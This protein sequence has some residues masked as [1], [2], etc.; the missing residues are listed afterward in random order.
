MESLR[1]GTNTLHSNPAYTNMQN[2]SPCCCGNQLVWICCQQCS[3]V[4]TYSAWLTHMCVSAECC[5]LVYNQEPGSAAADNSQN[6]PARHSC[7]DACADI[8]DLF[9]VTPPMGGPSSSFLQDCVCVSSCAQLYAVTPSPNP[10]QGLL[11][12]VTAP[13]EEASAA[14]S[15]VAEGED[16]PAVKA[17]LDAG[18]PHKESDLPQ[19]AP[20]EV[21]TCPS[22]KPTH[23]YALV[24]YRSKGKGWF[25]CWSDLCPAYMSMLYNAFLK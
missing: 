12:Q 16:P 6:H 9:Q 19:K 7:M 4:P 20:K 24:L 22:A 2:I 14:P 21:C 8:L 1:V 10:N 11:L 25:A 23:L 15:E 3:P 17:Q 13:K 18:P 5:L